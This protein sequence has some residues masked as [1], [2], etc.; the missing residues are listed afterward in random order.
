MTEAKTEKT[1]VAKKRAPR[2]TIEQ[3]RVEK[4]PIEVVPDVQ[5]PS[6]FKFK[7]EK[8]ALPGELK[9]LYTS[10]AE[11]DLAMARYLKAKEA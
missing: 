6:M 9:G 4:S 5:W 2:K 3:V 10:R 1:E 7:R 8:G 11:A